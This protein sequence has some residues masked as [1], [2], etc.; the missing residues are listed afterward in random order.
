M[1]EF[2]GALVIMDKEDFHMYGFL[3]EGATIADMQKI[4]KDDLE[5]LYSVAHRLYVLKAFKEAQKIF[6]ML[7]P[8]PAQGSTF[9]GSTWVL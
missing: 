1:T 8:L 7:C 2:F 4:D 6:E 5:R 9:L 3:G